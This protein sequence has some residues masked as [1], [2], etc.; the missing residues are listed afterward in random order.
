MSPC[1][2]HFVYQRL[3]NL[4][5]ARECFGAS[6]AYDIFNDLELEH[7]FALFFSSNFNSVL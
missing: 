3:V 6:I 4:C 2:Y 7:P 5:V 1:I